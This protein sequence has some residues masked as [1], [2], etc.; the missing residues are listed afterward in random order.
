MSQP[1]KLN[2][3]DRAKRIV[4]ILSVKGEIDV[5]DVMLQFEI[6]YTRAIPILKL[7]RKLCEEQQICQYDEREHKLVYM[8]KKVEKQNQEDEMKEINDI[9]NAKP[10]E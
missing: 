10:E 7:A 8:G 5:Y 2:D 3:V 6:S 1:K 9:M 4:K